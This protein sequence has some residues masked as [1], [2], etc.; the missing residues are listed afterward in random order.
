MRRSSAIDSRRS[1]GCAWCWDEFAGKH[2]IGAGEVNKLVYGYVDDMLSDLFFDKEEELKA[3]IE[4]D[5]ARER[6]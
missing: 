3:D 2:V 1:T 5:I 6:Q 4:E